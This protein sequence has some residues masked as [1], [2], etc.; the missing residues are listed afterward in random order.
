MW[1]DSSDRSSETGQMTPETLLSRYASAV[2]AVC[3]ANTRNL[4]DAEDIMQD[5]FLKA[6][7][8]F[9]S[10]RDHTRVRAWLLQI[11]R[12]TCIDRRRRRVITA[13]LPDDY[14]A[15]SVSGSPAVERLHAAM[16]QLPHEYRE[17]V[18][19]YYLD[20]RNCAGVA[21]A[22]GISEAAVR[23][24]LVRGRLMLHDILVKEGP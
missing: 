10:L 5:V 23:Q 22:L 20:G 19:L 8:N 24:R 16:S 2:M 12:R 3:L 13:T 14:P 7:S 1:A 6:V 21:E 4:H 18:S 15:P 9:D 11:A 17:T